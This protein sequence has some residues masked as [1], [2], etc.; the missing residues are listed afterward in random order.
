M[1]KAIKMIGLTIVGIIVLLISIV[2]LFI[3]LSPQFGRG[4][5]K[6][7]QVEYAKTNHYA[8]GKFLN[9]TPAI[10]LK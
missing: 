6:K 9:E 5:S 4:V 2:T 1:K 3:N 8:D 10:I 7:Q